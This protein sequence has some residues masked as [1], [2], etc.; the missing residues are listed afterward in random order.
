MA[1]KARARALVE[2]GRAPTVTIINLIVIAPDHIRGMARDGRAF[3]RTHCARV[4]EKWPRRSA[5][6]DLI[7]MRIRV[8]GFANRASCWHR[9]AEA[10][11]I[12]QWTRDE[13]R[14]ERARDMRYCAAREMPPASLY[15][16]HLYQMGYISDRCRYIPFNICEYYLKSMWYLRLGFIRMITNCVDIFC[17]L[18]LLQFRSIYYLYLFKYSLILVFCLNWRFPV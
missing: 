13:D 1:N 10:R 8:L 9:R 6:A 3:A 5:R 4:W 16:G 18:F 12:Q 15:Y 2:R 14:S 11:G 17:S 7:P